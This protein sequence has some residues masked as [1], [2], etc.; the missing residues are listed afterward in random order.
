MQIKKTIRE[1]E[2]LTLNAKGVKSVDIA[3]KFGITKQRIYQILSRNNISR[4]NQLRDRY[5]KIKNNAN[6][7]LVSGMSVNDITEKLKIKN[8][9][10]YVRD[11]GERHKYQRNQRNKLISDEFLNGMTAKKITKL[12]SPKELLTPTA[13]TKIGTVYAINSKLDIRRYP[14]IGDKSNG[15]I[16]ED[17]KILQYIQK[18]RDINKWTFIRISDKLNKLGYKTITGKEFTMCNTLAKYKAYKIKKHK[19]IRFSKNK[20]GM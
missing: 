9:Y 6:E 3:K 19:R 8:V 17:R 20:Y 16:F 5:S 7:L 14:M 2:I 4:V 10:Y 15:G 1:G 18:K 12:T 11:I 13:V